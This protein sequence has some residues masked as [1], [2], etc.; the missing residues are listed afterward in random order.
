MRKQ[1]LRSSRWPAG[2]GSRRS[3][4]WGVVF[5]FPP[6]LRL[7][8]RG[9]QADRPRPGLGFLSLAP[10]QKGAWTTA[11]DS[12]RQK[13]ASGKAEAGLPTPRKAEE[14]MMDGRTPAASVRSGLPFGNEMD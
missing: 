2:W 4:I 5:S 6:A 11:A 12:R 14:M 10:M 3:A 1:K 7:R 13:R 8:L 9:A